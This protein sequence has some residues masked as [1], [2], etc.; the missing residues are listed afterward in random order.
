MERKSRFHRKA[1]K[2]EEA[3]RI[4]LER[5][6]I[7]PAEMVPLEASFGRRLADGLTASSPVPHFRRSGMDGYAVRHDDAALATPQQPASLRIVGDV[8]AG[9]VWGSSLAPGTA[10]RVMTGAAVPEAATAVVMFEQTEELEQGA[11]VLIKQP[12][13]HGQNIAEIGDEIEGGQFLI[14]PGT[15][16]GP[17]Q[18]ALLATF[19][20]A[21][22]RVWRR[23]RVALFA[24]GS[25]LLP[26]DEPLAPGRIRNSNGPMLAAQIAA[27]GGVPVWLGILPDEPHIS[28]ARIDEALAQADIV[29]TTGGVSVGDYDAMSSLF[30]EGLAA[31]EATSFATLFNKVAVRPG[32]PAS[33]ATVGDKLLIGLS[34]N[35]GACF[36][37]FELFVR[38][39]LLRMQGVE[40]PLPQAIEAELSG[41]FPKGS[42]H[43]R[44]LRAKL[45]LEGGVV[46]VRPLGFAKSGMMVSIQDADALAIIP[47]GS[48]GAARGEIIEVL[49]LGYST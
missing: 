45:E 19:G 12:P 32:S 37:G 7:L 10:V 16:I 20:C 46:R 41:D 2:V 31:A 17:G 23:P 47:A 13:A 1:I 21:E 33:A 11:R 30:R 27:A 25:E 15:R 38:P 6:G 28:R 40:Q 42:P 8:P 29:V 22:V 3:Q 49:P 36:V 14:A 26:V 35:P 48:K 34:G 39:L 24:T 9:H 4:L 44:Y 18:A 5:V 43:D